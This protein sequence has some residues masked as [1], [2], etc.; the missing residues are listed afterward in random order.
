MQI[1]TMKYF[2]PSRWQT[3][4]GLL[5]P[6]VGKCQGKGIRTFSE[7]LLANQVE[8]AI[9]NGR[10]FAGVEN[11]RVKQGEPKPSV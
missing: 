9:P 10:G 2:H 1:K 11:P 8:S 4:K 3:P 6:R 7:H 5:T